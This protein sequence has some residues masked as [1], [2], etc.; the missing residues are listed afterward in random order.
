MVKQKAHR[1]SGPSDRPIAPPGWILGDCHIHSDASDGSFDPETLRTLRR[2]HNHDFVCVTDHL[3]LIE[4]GYGWP[5]YVAALERDSSPS[6]TLCPGVE[7]T[8]AENAGDALGFG[9]PLTGLARVTN[10]AHTCADLIQALKKQ[11]PFASA[12]IAHPGGGL[13]PI[14][15]AVCG[16]GYDGVQIVNGL[17]ADDA[18]AEQIWLESCTVHRETCQAAALGGSDAHKAFEPTGMGTWLY[19]P[20]WSIAATWEEKINAIAA[21]LKAGQ[22][23]ATEQGSFALLRVEDGLPGARLERP[24]RARIGYTVQLIARQN[25]LRAKVDWQVVRTGKPLTGTVIDLATDKREWSIG[26]L[27]AEVVSGLQSYYLVANFTYF[28]GDLPS[29]QDKVYCGPIYVTGVSTPEAAIAEEAGV[30]EGPS[31]KP[32]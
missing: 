16:C 23:I 10:K 3:D 7:V 30:P 29:D 9:M 26:P 20:E 8:C 14:R 4:A 32:G 6:F 17:T 1:Q 11:G 15:W 28:D 24:I 5:D 27:R 12:Y 19:A 22:T 21:A 13:G 25:E 2:L 31:S 18:Q